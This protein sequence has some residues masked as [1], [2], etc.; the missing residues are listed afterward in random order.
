MAVPHFE[1][2][3]FILAPHAL[4]NFASGGTCAVHFGQTSQFAIGAPQLVQN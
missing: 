2:S 3:W 1:H 4:Q